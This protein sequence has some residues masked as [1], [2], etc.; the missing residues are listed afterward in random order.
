VRRLIAAALLA[1]VAI[2]PASAMPGQSLDDFDRWSR[3]VTDLHGLTA[4]SGLDGAISYTASFKAG[5]TTAEFRAVSD[6]AQTHVV[7]ESIVYAGP[8]DFR[9]DQ[10]REIAAR[11]L[12][13]VYGSTI[14]DDFR[15]APV[16]ATGYGDL[17]TVAYRGKL[18]GYEAAGERVT[19][20]ALADF[21]VDLICIAANTCPVGD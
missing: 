4:Q 17:P 3:G 15:S 13:A 18:F 19:V 5:I 11:L 20:R 8:D 10:H 21:D 2:A 1:L 16:A 9:L 6:P 7:R 14:A 12:S